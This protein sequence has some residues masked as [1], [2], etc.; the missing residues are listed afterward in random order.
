MDF[1]LE[2]FNKLILLTCDLE[3]QNYFSSSNMYATIYS[4]QFS[5]EPFFFFSSGNLYGNESDCLLTNI[6]FLLEVM[7]FSRIRKNNDGCRT[8]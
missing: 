3:L 2:I 4:R 8:L 1:S 7:K 6:G 5:G